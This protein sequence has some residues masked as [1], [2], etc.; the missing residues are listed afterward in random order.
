MLHLPQDVLKQEKEERKTITAS[1]H[2]QLNYAS[3]SLN[4]SERAELL[5]AKL[6][7]EFCCCRNM[8]C[9]CERKVPFVFSCTPF[10]SYRT[11]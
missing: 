8:L 11:S 5:K 1:M 2:A 6:L 3:T 7:F 4:A 9:Q 10:P